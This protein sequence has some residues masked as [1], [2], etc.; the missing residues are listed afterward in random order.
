LK[1]STIFAAET[2][3]LPLLPKRLLKMAM[4]IV[5]ETALFSNSNGYFRFDH[6]GFAIL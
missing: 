5:S 4:N 6:W 3:P 2:V 1:Q